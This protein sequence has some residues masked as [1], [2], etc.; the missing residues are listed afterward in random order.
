MPNFKNCKEQGKITPPQNHIVQPQN[1]KS[2]RGANCLFFAFE[3]CFYFVRM[4]SIH[5]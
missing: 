3:T 4:R 2:R 1:P 5:V